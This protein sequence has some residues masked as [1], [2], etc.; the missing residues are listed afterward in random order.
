MTT[1]SSTS[2]CIVN[3]KRETICCR[4]GRPCPPVNGVLQL[5]KYIVSTQII[6]TFSVISD[7][8]FDIF[9]FLDNK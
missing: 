1:E 2:T 9:S 5:P 6:L 3:N 7:G 8:S 4:G